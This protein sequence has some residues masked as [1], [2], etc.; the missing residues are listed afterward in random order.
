MI[1]KPTPAAMDK[2]GDEFC[3]EKGAAKLG[4]DEKDGWTH[5]PGG[6]GDGWRTRSRSRS[7][8]DRAMSAP[9]PQP[10]VTS[11]KAPGQEDEE[12]EDE[13]KT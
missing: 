11:M 4:G 3:F 1:G 8:D 5:C 12:Q 7:N 13:K 9:H 10:E 2:T 6:V